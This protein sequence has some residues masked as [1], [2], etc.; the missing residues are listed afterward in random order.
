MM[1]DDALNNYDRV[2]DKGMQI[3]RTRLAWKRTVLATGVLC[4]VGLKAMQYLD[5]RWRLMTLLLVLLF[6][7]ECGVYLFRKSRYVAWFVHIDRQEAVD[8]PIAG[9]GLCGIAW[10]LSTLSV[11]C[12]VLTLM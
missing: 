11:T 10:L 5:Q 4:C 6:L 7:I 12:L 3:E 2:V 8:Q 9:L 1:N